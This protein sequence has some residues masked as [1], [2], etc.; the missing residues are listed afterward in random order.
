[1]IDCNACYIHDGNLLSEVPDSAPSPAPDGIDI[2]QSCR[3]W[4]AAGR[5]STHRYSSRPWLH[6][7]RAT[8]RLEV[9]AVI[10]ACRSLPRTPLGR[11]IRRSRQG[12]NPEIG[13]PVARPDLQMVVRNGA[14]MRA[15][16]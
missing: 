6:R 3:S 12:K 13:A 9:R 10:P 1:M 4:L 14:G 5:I 2:L 15:T 16:G 7:Q 11:P 8:T